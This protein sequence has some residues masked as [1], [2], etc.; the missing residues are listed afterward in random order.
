MDE[1]EIAR[2]LERVAVG[3]RVAFRTLYRRTS[4]RLY[5]VCLRVVHDSSRAQSA[6]VDAYAKVWRYAE[7]FDPADVP[8]STWLIAIARHNAIMRARNGAQP[9]P[10]VDA[11]L[12]LAARPRETKALARLNGRLADCLARLDPS[13]AALVRAAYFGGVT[14]TGLAELK[15]LDVAAARRTLA[16]IARRL[17]AC[18]AP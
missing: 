12:G 15:G 14:E 5:A 9:A 6:L 10:Q 1:A 8:A 13:E 3:D 2:L 7:R 16:D 11:A 18:L 4:P 17:G